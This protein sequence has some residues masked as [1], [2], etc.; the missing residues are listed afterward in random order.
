[1]SGWQYKRQDG[2]VIGILSEDEI[3][4]CA[5]R[6]GISLNSP[7][8][9][10]EKTQGKWVAASR[11]EPLRKRIE[12]IERER[13]EKEASEASPIAEYVPPPEAKP[14]SSTLGVLGQGV[15]HVAISI[16]QNVAAVAHYLTAKKPLHAC[17]KCEGEFASYEELGKCP[18][19]GEWAVV[20][21]ET[22]G[23]ES[24]AKRFVA[25]GCKCPRCGSKVSI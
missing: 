9:H 23:L 15:A 22:C 5:E 4:H 16:F 13:R 24:G 21:C 12:A 18:L 3:K 10:D 1:M 14:S 2:E 11:F 20:V 8:K 19:C 6:G 25:I 17:L 7:V